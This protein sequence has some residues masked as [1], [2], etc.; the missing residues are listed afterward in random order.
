MQL[1]QFRAFSR[2]LQQNLEGDSRVLGLVFLGSSAE[3]G[4][5]PDEYSDHDFFVLT[6][7]GVQ[8]D[9]RRNLSWLPD[10]GNIVISYRETA[11]GLKVIF[12]NGHLVEFAIFDVE[13]L[14]LA[15]VN[16]YRVAF[17]KA[18]IAE[19]LKKVQALSSTSAL[20]ALA[21]MQAFLCNLQIGL[22]RCRR[23]EILSGERLIKQYAFASLLTLLGHY[24][25]S[26][27]KSQLDN[28]DPYRRF[29]FVFPELG[30]E[31]H[32][33]LLQDGLLAAKSLL[34]IADREL[35]AT[36]PDYPTQAVELI[37]KLTG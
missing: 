6:V 36:M 33:A 16:D 29:E 19:R 21:E 9:F 11:H 37:R 24:L 10:S 30:R 7:T 1:D 13:E 26:A 17:D 4:R 8:E 14:F 3:Q 12:A 28:L 20:N 15:R 34:T 2:A 23:G 18:E 25:P 5:S 31:F 22:G 32:D 27:D 35:G